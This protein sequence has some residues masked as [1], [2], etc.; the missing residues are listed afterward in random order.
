M[1]TPC[2][3][4]GRR[5]AKLVVV[6]TRQRAAIEAAG[7]EANI[8]VTR[9]GTISTLKSAADSPA[10]RWLDAVGNP[11]TLTLQGFDHFYAD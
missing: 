6:A 2:R 7:R 3:A 11:L 4:H 1:S 9:I 10:I 8:P 5:E